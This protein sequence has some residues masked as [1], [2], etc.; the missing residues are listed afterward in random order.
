M[1][2][3]FFFHLQSHLWLVPQANTCASPKLLRNLSHYRLR[4]ENFSDFLIFTSHPLVGGASVS[5]AI[6]HHCGPFYLCILCVG[7]SPRQR[8]RPSQCVSITEAAKRRSFVLAP[9]HALPV[10]KLQWWVSRSW[11]SL[12]ATE[13]HVDGQG[14]LISDRYSHPLLGGE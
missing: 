2:S 14:R 8:Q 4:L 9:V 5:E 11:R 7:R 6:G 13:L 12:R 10:L 3:H 1:L